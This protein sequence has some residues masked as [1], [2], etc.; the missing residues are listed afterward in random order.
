M[1]MKSVLRTFLIV[2]ALSSLEAHA[3]LTA[4]VDRDPVAV[5]ESLTLTVISDSKVDG[6]PDFS[7]LSPYFEVLNQSSSSSV[8]Y[9]NGAVS[10][11]ITWQVGLIPKREGKIQIPAFEIDGES[12]QPFVVTVES[13]HTPQSGQAGEPLFMEAMVDVDDV[14]VQQQIIL[15][16]QF[17]RSVNIAGSALSDLEV[18]GVDAIV[19]QLGDDREFQK[20]ID[21]RRHVV[22]E[23]KYV[24]HPQESGTLNIG[25]MA[26]DV[27][28]LNP[29]G[30]QRYDPFNRNTIRKRVRSEPIKLDV[31][32]IPAGMVGNWLPA[33]KLQ[34]AEKWSADKFIVGEP[35]TRTIGVVADG[36]TSA[37]LPDVIGTTPDTVKVYPDQPL[38][39]DTKEANGIVGVRQQ[40]L[41]IIPTQTGKLTLPAIRLPWWNTQTQKLEVAKLPERTVMV[42]AAPQEGIAKP[43]VPQT[44]AE[45][46]AGN[47]ANETTAPLL[48]AVTTTVVSPGWWPWVSLVLG[49][50]W[51]ITFIAWWRK[52]SAKPARKKPAKADFPA[53]RVSENLLKKSCQ[54]NDA[55]QA[56]QALLAWAK[57]CWGNG[58]TNAAPTSLPA[59]ARLC[60]TPLADLL[61][62]LDAAL[63]ANKQSEWQGA[64]L[65]QAFS[66]NKPK[67][68]VG[69]GDAESELEPLY[70]G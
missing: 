42:V 7:I 3:A 48:P 43:T 47:E 64:E 62:A 57:Q 1:F 23:R 17:Y 39:K 58:S 61:V 31:K 5:D 22:F 35:I 53:M 33:R 68:V 29:R 19:E 15:T 40:K 21:G 45:G 11:S 65:W 9:A 28:M 18:G 56:K 30:N 59:M 16:V 66:Q 34:L 12:S 13:A 46:D 10:R 52:D 55:A 8:Q 37:Q 26:F 60:D 32:P 50:A 4:S 27:N 49:I 63:Y 36:L 54:Q 20:T 70:R 67:P 24:I 25:A 69:S 38:L 6:Q 51:L 41:A 44:P 2:L 14:Y